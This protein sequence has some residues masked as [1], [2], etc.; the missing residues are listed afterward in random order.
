MN[1][2]PRA[3]WMV[4]EFKV[5]HFREVLMRPY[6]IIYELRGDACYIVAVIHGSRDLP[7]HIQRPPNPQAPPE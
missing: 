4:P 5:D 2:G 6:R 3:G 1:L 7:Q